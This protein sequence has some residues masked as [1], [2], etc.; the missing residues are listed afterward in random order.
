MIKDK[1][2]TTPKLSAQEGNNM[3]TLMVPSSTISRPRDFYSL[4]Q[5]SIHNLQQCQGL[6]PEP[7]WRIIQERA[8]LHSTSSPQRVKYQ[9]DLILPRRGRSS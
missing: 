2:Y 1:N 8:R 5:A 3:R 4:S 9:P 7:K 6:V